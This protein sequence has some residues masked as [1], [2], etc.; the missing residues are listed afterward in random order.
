MT[1]VSSYILQRKILVGMV[2]KL[3]KKTA[4]RCKWALAELD[5]SG[6]D[7]VDPGASKVKRNMIIS[8]FESMYSLVTG[9][10]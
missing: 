9:I 10:Q 5:K 3:T 2:V 1:I 7:T 4:A 6:K 8:T